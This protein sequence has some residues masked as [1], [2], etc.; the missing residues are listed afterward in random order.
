MTCSMSP[1]EEGHLHRRG[2]CLVSRLRLQQ[3]D[4]DRRYQVKGP[5]CGRKNAVQPAVRATLVDPRRS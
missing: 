1:A 3:H 5:S 2:A 4:P